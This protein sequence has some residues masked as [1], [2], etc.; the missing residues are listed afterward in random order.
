MIR[1][2][3]EFN[4]V[5]LG[6][7][8]PCEPT[9]LSESRRDW[10]LT[11]M[12]EE[13]DEFAESVTVEEAADAIVDLCY[14]AIGRGYEMGVDLQPVFDAVHQAN[15]NKVRG[16]LSKRP[17]SL[18]YD[19][20]K[21]EGWTP[22]EHTLQSVLN[23]QLPKIIIIGHAR[24]GKDTV[25]EILRD[26]YGFKFQSASL[27]L[28]EHVIMPKLGGY[29][30]AEECYADRLTR[31]KEW[32]DIIANYIAADKAKAGKLVFGCSDIYCGIR[33][34]AE[35]EACKPA[36]DYTI[37]VDAGRRCPPESE[38]SC[39]VKPQMADRII[40]NNGDLAS[41]KASVAKAMKGIL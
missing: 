2:V 19:A 31:R 7:P 16:S 36:A 20:V 30:N 15:M 34:V 29:D 38:G 27:L 18:G 5:V 40:D 8:V 11:A 4:R 14:F 28:A 1:E 33:N 13:L 12:K 25:C 22:P 32:Y 35:L 9:M 24:H 37:W 41:L 26:D 21:P 17:N 39:T 3:E 6:L 10:A 23:R